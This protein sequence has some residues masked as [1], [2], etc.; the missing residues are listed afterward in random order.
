LE[1]ACK[2][3]VFSDYAVGIGLALSDSMR[4]IKNNLKINLMKIAVFVF[5]FFC[6]TLALGQA[7]GGSLGGA[8]MASSIQMESHPE[9]ASQRAMAEEHIILEHS[10]FYSAEGERPLWEFKSSVHH[11]PLGDIAR[12]LR[13]EHATAKK[14]DIVLND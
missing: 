2:A 7:A 3:L 1:Y 12:M 10:N 8:V 9:H 11:V 5:C 4:T 13:Q 14:A 6:T